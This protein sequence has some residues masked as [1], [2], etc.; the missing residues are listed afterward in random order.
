MP[1]DEDWK[2]FDNELLQ[3]LHNEGKPPEYR[4]KDH[5]EFRKMMLMRKSVVETMLNEVSEGMGISS[6]EDFSLPP[7]WQATQ[8]GFVIK[9]GTTPAAAVRSIFG[10]GKKLVRLDC[11]SM[12]VAVQYKGMLDAFGDDKFNEMFP[13]GAGLVISQ[14]DTLDE[15]VP[16]HPF[17]AKKAYTEHVSGSSEM[18]I[19]IDPKDPTKELLPGDWVYFAN[20]AEY[21]RM[22]ARLANMI[23][24]IW[25]TLPKNTDPKLPPEY[26]T[27]FWQGEHAVYV[28][29]ENFTGLGFDKPVTYDEMMN[30]LLQKYEK[31][32]QAYCRWPYRKYADDS[33]ESDCMAE[34]KAKAAGQEPQL[35]RVLRLDYSKLSELSK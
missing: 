29:H 33:S 16:P 4:F 12:M 32:V 27:N 25:E 28:G 18:R 35:A 13:G 14:T 22:T 2:E 19:V 17:V 31:V 1:T 6:D 7:E 24:N 8:K 20:I 34:W 15:T 5:D 3:K 23:D 26:R 11:N 9:R 30:T 21:K 10:S